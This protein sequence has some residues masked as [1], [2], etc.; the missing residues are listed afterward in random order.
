ME[1]QQNK[2]INSFASTPSMVPPHTLP[3]NYGKAEGTPLLEL[4]PPASIH[5]L[6]L[7]AL[8]PPQP[9]QTDSGS[10][11][12]VPAGSGTPTSPCTQAGQCN[13]R[14]GDCRGSALCNDDT[15]ILAIACQPTD[16]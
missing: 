13:I 7:F 15:G 10:S 5:G 9:G 6:A 3:P 14:T 12:T 1:P 16:K 11:S 2:T 4:A 8:T